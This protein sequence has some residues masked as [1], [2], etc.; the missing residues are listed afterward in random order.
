MDAI[1]MNTVTVDEIERD[2]ERVREMASD[3]PV[4]LAGGDLVVLTRERYERMRGTRPRP[5]ADVVPP[6]DP[7]A[8]E[9]DRLLD[10]LA[11]VDETP[12]E[13]APRA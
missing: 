3:G 10:T 9:L 1:P 5:V 4:S 13:D 2:Y 6:S 11:D 7:L 8:T 12:M